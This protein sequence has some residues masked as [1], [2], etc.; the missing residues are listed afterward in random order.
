MSFEQEVLTHAWSVLT[1]AWAERWMLI[2]ALGS[3]PVLAMR[4]RPRW[5]LHPSCDLVRRT[6]AL[7]AVVLCLYSG[8]LLA[9]TVRVD[10]EGA[11]ALRAVSCEGLGQDGEA[12]RALCE[13]RLVRAPWVSGGAPGMP[14]QRVTAWKLPY[15]GE[16]VAL[17]PSGSAPAPEAR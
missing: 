12:L 6:G 5:A 14:G 16:L 11:A 3:G 15:S 7:F 4:L 10:D 1:R 2:V 9:D 8:Y 17:T 13:G